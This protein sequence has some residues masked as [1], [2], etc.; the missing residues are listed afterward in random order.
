MHE[1]TELRKREWAHFLF[2]PFSL[3]ADF[4][5]LLMVIFF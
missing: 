4:N 1:V 2:P 5:S 3:F